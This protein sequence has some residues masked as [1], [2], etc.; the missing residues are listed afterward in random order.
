MNGPIYTPPGIGG[1]D[2]ADAQTMAAVRSVCF[3][4]LSQ[5]QDLDLNLI[6]P[7]GSCHSVKQE[8]WTPREERGGGGGDD[9]KQAN[10]A[11]S[12]MQML[13]ESCP[14]KTAVSGVMGFALGGAFGLFMASVRSPS[15]ILPPFLAPPPSPSNK[16][17]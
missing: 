2:G 17:K 9:E 6:P 14:G 3:S 13:M 15:H 10:Y 7:R 4:H 16:R 5:S 1:N 12:Q 11:L 8:A